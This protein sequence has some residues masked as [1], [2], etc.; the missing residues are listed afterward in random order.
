MGAYYLMYYRSVLLKGFIGIIE[1]VNCWPV[2]IVNCL[3]NDATCTDIIEW[4]LT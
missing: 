4:L 2:N 1:D 3:Q